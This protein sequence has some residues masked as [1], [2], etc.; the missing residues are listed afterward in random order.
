MLEIDRLSSLGTPLA[1]VVITLYAL[2]KIWADV[3]PWFTDVYWVSREQRWKEQAATIHRR[4]A[5]Y[6]ALATRFIEALK[7]YQNGFRTQATLEH[8]RIIAQIR[9]L[10]EMLA[11]LLDPRYEGGKHRER[12]KTG[13]LKD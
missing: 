7:D 13:P 11:R 12:A 8:E 2:R 1:I 9:E 6:D 4:D 10:G 5:A 3:W